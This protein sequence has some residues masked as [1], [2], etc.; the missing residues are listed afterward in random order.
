MAVAAESALALTAGRATVLFA[1]GP[2]FGEGA[3]E[4]RLNRILSALAPELEAVRWARQVHGYEL[5]VIR[6]PVPRGVGNVGN[7]D[8]LATSLSGVGLVVWT[9][10]CVPVVLVGSHGVAIA[11]AGWRGSAGGI[12][13]ATV[14]ALQR[15]FVTRPADLSAFL[16]PSI[17]GAHYQV[18]P[19]VIDAL[20]D[21]GIDDARWR[22]G[23]R[24]DLRAFLTAQ[25][26]SLGVA[27]VRLVGPCTFATPEFASY[28]R[29]SDAAG[30]QW[31]MVYLP[32][33]PTPTHPV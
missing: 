21:T 14:A 3:G 5:A 18:G 23:D 26:E 31:S 33:T 28:R 9:A 11:H 24:V 15:E 16:G 12:V 32:K 20:G 29:D 30:R 6:E 2:A 22:A 7:R 4:H 25:L 8:A 17:S 27:D 13:P 10:D 19:E 1:I